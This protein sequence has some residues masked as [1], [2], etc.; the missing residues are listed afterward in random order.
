MVILTFNFKFL[1]IKLIN[2]TKSYSSKTLFKNVNI[3]I[4]KNDKIG[5]VGKNGQGKSTFLKILNGITEPEKGKVIIDPP[6]SVIGYHKQ[7]IIEI[8]KDLSIEQY[9]LSKSPKLYKIKNSLDKMSYKLKRSPKNNFLLNRFVNLNSQYE[10]KGGFV[11]E[12]QI[13]KLLS[14]LNI[15]E[16][17]LQT[18]VRTLSGGQKTRLQLVNLL[19]DKTNILLLDEPTNNL[20]IEAIKWLEQFVINFKGIILIISHDRALLN[21]TVNKI[22][23]IDNGKVNLYS[24]NFDYYKEQKEKDRI[25]REKEYLR[26]IKKIKKLQFEANKK[27]SKARST[28][29]KIRGKGVD[30]YSAIYIRASAGKQAKTARI[31]K[32]KIQKEIENNVPEKMKRKYKIKFD[33]QPLRNSGNQVVIL[34]NIYKYYKNKEILKNINLEI[35]R[36]EKVLLDGP[37]GS[38]KST[39]MKIITSRIKPDCGIVKLGSKVDI[40]YFCQE[41]EELNLK[42]SVIEEF[43]TNNNMDEEEARAFLHQMLFTGDQVFQKISSLSQGEKSKLI[44]AKLLVKRHNFLILDE[45][46]NHLDIESIEVIEE[47]LRNYKGTLLI[48]S[49]DRTFLNRI[50]INRKMSL[51]SNHKLIIQPV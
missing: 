38:G 43:I 5:I 8:D 24:G 47:S 51:R 12:N 49:H 44:L 14:K 41:Q 29:A 4:G 1:F 27:E 26:E 37:N 39:L 22:L 28:T 48:V 30:G 10:E 25:K 16:F 9:I 6:G 7:F 35:S 46:L 3:S 18:K 50:G 33:I 13:P 31:Y 19:S 11:L 23:E 17:S 21:K 20:D 36:G 42:N 2:I 32:D 15:G 34:R 40:G 45:P